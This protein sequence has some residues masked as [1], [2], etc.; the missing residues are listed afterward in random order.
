VRQYKSEVNQNG[1]F[2]GDDFMESYAADNAY[3]SEEDIAD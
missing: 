1:F 2:D 3:S